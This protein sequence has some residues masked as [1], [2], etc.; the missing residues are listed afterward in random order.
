MNGGQPPERYLTFFGPIRVPQT[1][2]LRAALCG[3]VNEG[4]KKI[5]ILFSS[6]GGS[7]EDGIALYTYLTALPVE[8]TMHAVGIVGS[9][10]IPV[11]LSAPIRLASDN[12]HFFFHEY[13]WT[14]PLAGTVTQT[15]M[16][17]QNI[18]LGGA[19]EWSK[20]IIKTKTKLTNAEFESRKM[21]DNP[22]RFSAADAVTAGIVSSVAE[23]KIP[24]GSQPRVVI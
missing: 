6:D 24:A 23:P 14:H 7:T 3:M 4:A 5:T 8:L 15:T 1:T 18:L 20:K 10:A 9:I 2:S 17:E 12:A 11:F 21:F 19:L 22:A 13:T 16:E